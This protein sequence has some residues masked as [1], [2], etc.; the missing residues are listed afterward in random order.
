MIAGAWSIQRDSASNGG[1]I[2]QQVL[3]AFPFEQ[4]T[5]IRLRD[6]D[7][8]YGHEFPNQVDVMGITEVLSAP[9]SPWQRAYVE[10]VIGSIRMA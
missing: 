10:R 4:H 9:R 3:E 6:R 5:E 7:G 8:I 2:A 1:M